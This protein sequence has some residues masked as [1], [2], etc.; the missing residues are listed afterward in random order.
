MRPSTPLYPKGLQ[1]YWR[2]DFVRD[3]PDEAID[4]HTHG[5]PRQLPTPHSTMHLYPIDGAVH[6]VGAVGHRVGLPRRHAGRR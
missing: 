3:L 1:W 2:G 4:A 6:D 5:S